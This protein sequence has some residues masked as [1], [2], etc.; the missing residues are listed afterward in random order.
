MALPDALA[1]DEWAMI[2]SSLQ[3]TRGLLETHADRTHDGVLALNL[4]K[5]SDRYRLL[6]AKIANLDWQARKA[7]Y[8]RQQAADGLIFLPV[9]TKHGDM[10]CAHC[11]AVTA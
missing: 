8:D 3:Q 9:C 10:T 11:Q 1:P 7:E 2:R 4:D 5:L 6:E